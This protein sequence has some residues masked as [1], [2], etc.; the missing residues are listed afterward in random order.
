MHPVLVYQMGKVGS[1]SIITS[2]EH[3]GYN[4]HHNL[5]HIHELRD[6][7]R[8]KKDEN[9]AANHN[10][11]NENWKIITLVRDIV[12]RNVSDFFHNLSNVD[13]AGEWYVGPEENVR[14]LG[15]KELSNAFI[16]CPMAKHLA[17]LN[18]FDTQLKQFFGIDVFE[19]SFDCEWKIYQEK[20]LLIRLE[21][22]DRASSVI[23][24]FLNIDYK[25]I[26]A[27]EAR[28]KWYADKYEKFRRQSVLPPAYLDMIY[29]SRFMRHF[30][31]NEEILK[32]RNQWESTLF[33]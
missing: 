29:N 10:E 18:W 8:T 31:N 28:K 3:A 7:Q 12:S 2:L 17:P 5:L 4:L 16:A 32:F 25:S 23:G 20:A 15:I 14:Q 21:D 30:Y 33:L 13:R 1:T 19:H 11:I 22:L 6:G 9:I 27:N 24:D 26:R